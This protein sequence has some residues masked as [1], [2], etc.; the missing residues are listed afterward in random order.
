MLACVL[1]TMLY[2]VAESDSASISIEFL[3][4]FG[5]D[6]LNMN[7]SDVFHFYFR[8]C[9]GSSIMLLIICKR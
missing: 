4:P 5:I 7:L 3:Y 8:G 9:S 2:M 1:I 6:I